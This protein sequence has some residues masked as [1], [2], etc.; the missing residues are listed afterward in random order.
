MS[1]VVITPHYSPGG[2]WMPTIPDQIC[3]YCH[4]SYTAHSRTS[5][6]CSR[7]CATNHRKAQT[8]AKFQNCLHC[9]KPFE[10][11]HGGGKS[12]AASAKYCS[13]ECVREHHSWHP[14][15]TTQ[16]DNCGDDF[17]TSVSQSRIE[18]G[19]GV[20]CS[21]ACYKTHQ[22]KRKVIKK[23][24]ECGQEFKVSPCRSEELTCSRSC[25]IKHFKRDR[26]KG[27]KGGVVAQNK[28][29]F[30]RIDRDGYKAKY[31][32]E[33][34]LTAAREI[35]RPIKRGEVIMCIDEKHENLSPDNLFICPNQ[36]EYGLIRMG[37]VKWPAAS[38][39]AQFRLAGYQRPDVI[40]VLH[41]WEQGRR[42]NQVSKRRITRH[43]QADEIIERRKA[44]ASLRDLAAG[45]ETSTSTMNEI[46]KTRL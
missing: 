4:K 2:Y 39:L 27:W 24:A 10:I 29:A 28:R 23:C 43:P 21:K 25:R 5:L 12:R 11:P 15:A 17:T 8:P 46:L 41:E 19:R 36:K 3:Q 16:C 32:G 45:F 44:G 18:T 31:D 40:I 7:L 20:F 1:R 13:R 9:K 6:F 33:H 37:A 22:Q 26:S 35:G 42:L 30:R 34:R 38:N 14:E